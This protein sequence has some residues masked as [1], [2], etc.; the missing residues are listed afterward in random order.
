[1]VRLFNKRASMNGTTPLTKEDKERAKQLKKALKASTQN[2][3]K[4]TSLFEDG[5]MHI[6]DEEY[7]KTWELG[8]TNYLT[9]DED[10]KLDIIDYYVEALN[11]LDSDNTYQLLIINRPVPSTL[12]SQITYELESDDRDVYRQE[13][14]DMITSRFATD[15][16]NFKVE[17]FITVSTSARDRKQAYR[18]LNDVENNFSKQ[19]QVIDI[20]FTPLTGTER[21][22][23]FADLLRGNPYLNVDYK[24]VR[25]SGLTT[26]SFVAPG[27]FWFQQ[28]QFMMDKK[29]CKVL[30]ARSF[31]AF[32]NDRLIKS[33]TDIGI[34]LAITIHA[35][36]YDPA[37]AVQKIN[38]AEAG[39]KMD[40]IKSQ[41]VAADKGISGNLAVSGVAQATAEE[42][43]KWSTEINDNDQKMF[44]GIFAV[45]LKADTPE[46][47]ADYTNRVK[48]AGRKHVVDFEETYYHQEEAL[49]TMLPIGKTY[50][51]VKR[52][53][54][55]DMTTTNIATQIP[56]TNTD[57]QSNSPM[58]IYYGQ[59]QISNN[60]I[61]LDRQR[62]LNTSSGV[63]LGSSGSGKSVFVKTSEVIP[64][65]LRYPDDRII[66]VDPEDEYSDIGRAFD[67]QL[68]DIFPGSQTHLNLM[69]LPDEENLSAE[70]ADPI[71]E[72]SSLIMGLFENILQEVTD[73]DFSII[74]RVT[75]LCYEQI[76]DR[77]PTLKDWYN[78]LLEQPEDVAQ[79]L[80]LK[81][82]SYTNGSQDIFAHETNVNLNNQ[83]VIFNLK[84]LDGKLKP[85]A[86]MVVQDYIWNQVVNNQGK[87]TTRIYFDEMQNQFL[88]DNQAEFFTN[89]Y[90]RVRKYGAIPT[91][92]TQNVE[93]LLARTEGRKLI[94]N[95]EFIVLL[96][97]KKTDLQYL[98]Q[99]I[100]LT[101]ALIRYVEKPKA[102]GTGLIIAGQ[103]AVPFENPIPKNTE[104]FRLVATDAYR[105]ID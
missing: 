92:I 1:M 105:Q 24:D 86:L 68:I 65:I 25:I 3:I 34:E 9:A 2:T 49:N 94:S 89:L 78:I 66:I 58:A 77:T 59:N 100:N 4:Y 81:S 41:K 45:M 38:T 52:R 7:S 26:K 84:K 13:Y 18:K 17:K 36:P 42:A 8:D 99:T 82:E 74:D 60:I 15:Q 85:F 39:V 10:E 80:A 88:T 98:T 56:F 83:V 72:K 32:L 53:F 31:P 76:T 90:A 28:D 48:Q 79:D 96:K 102:K 73:E 75:R 27:R 23:I 95:S 44:S 97:Q 22:N 29:Y 63:I 46:E 64:T 61:T 54:M 71:G 91:G 69:D 12:L 19:F 6:V 87:L 33:I 40:M 30:F 43:A 5:L 11:G 35:K 55:R 57:L 103:T 70:D 62:D 93:T 37:D 51:D 16:N 104:L 50:L 14:N 47:L 67:A 20:P 101:D 21:L